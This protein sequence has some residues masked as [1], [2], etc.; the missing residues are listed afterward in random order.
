VRTSVLG[1]DAN[2]GAS[3]TLGRDGS[4]DLSGFLTIGQRF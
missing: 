3:T 1:L 4:Q 2:L